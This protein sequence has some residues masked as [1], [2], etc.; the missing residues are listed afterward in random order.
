MNSSD[1]TPDNGP[2]VRARVWVP[3]ALLLAVSVAAFLVL[4]RG[5]SD[6]FGPLKPAPP[7]VWSPSHADDNTATAWAEGIARYRSDEFDHA[8]V[9]LGRA[10]AG[11]PEQSTP[12]FYAGVCHLLLDHP[13]AASDLLQKAVKNDPN[14]SMTRYYLAWSLHLMDADEDAIEQLERAAEGDDSWAAKAGRTASK[15]R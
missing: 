3:L 5:S 2:L 11:M 9:W 7:P 1:Q 6:A 13:D 14:D 8:A 15:L 10:A 12:L 4:G